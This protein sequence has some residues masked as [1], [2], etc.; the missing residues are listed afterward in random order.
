MPEKM[1][2]RIDP[3]ALTKLVDEDRL[4]LCVQCSGYDFDIWIQNKRCRNCQPKEPEPTA[5]F[6]WDALPLDMACGC[7][8]W[9]RAG[10]AAVRVAHCTPKPPQVPVSEEGFNQVRHLH[11]TADMHEQGGF[12]DV[13]SLS[14]QTAHAHHWA[15]SDA[16]GVFHCTGCPQSWTP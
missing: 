16:P 7:R 8:Y 9:N 1:N 2:I 15:K 13:Q 12:E 5:M 14:A 6:Y 3:E 11:D 10:E 4:S